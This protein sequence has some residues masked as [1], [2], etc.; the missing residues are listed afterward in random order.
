MIPHFKKLIFETADKKKNEIPDEDNILYQTKLLFGHLEMSERP[1][2]NPISFF[3]SIKDYDGS[4]MP[5]NE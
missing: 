2:H 5:T 1:V 4:I 3:R